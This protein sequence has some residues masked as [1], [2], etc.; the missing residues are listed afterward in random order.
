MHVS[1]LIKLAEVAIFDHNQ[2]LAAI[3]KSNKST[4]CFEYWPER[5]AASLTQLD[6]RIERLAK[7]KI[8]KLQK[9]TKIKLR[10]YAV[11]TCN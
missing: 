1:C 3:L 4:F 10:L 6:I 5:D 8:V 2:S 7:V 11:K 9:H